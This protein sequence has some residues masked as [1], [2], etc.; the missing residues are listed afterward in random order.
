MI[1]FIDVRKRYGSAAAVDGVTLS[2]PEGELCVLLGPSGS[3]KTTLLRMTNRLVEPTSGT[4]RI[5][6]RDILA[7]DPVTLRRRIGYAIQSVGLFPH[8]T[9]AENIATTPELLGMK[10]IGGRIDEL[11]EMMKLDP[12][13][14]RDRYPAEL[15]GGEAQRVGV[16][17]A[18]A[19]D[20]PLL[21]MDEPFGAIDPINRAAIR[22]Q[23]L[24]LQGR[25]RKTIL[26]VSHDIQEAIQLA[27]RI[28]LLRDGRLEQFGTPAKLVA[29][30]ANRFVESFF[31]GDRRMLL[32][33]ALSAADA[34]EP[35]G[36]ASSAAI[37]AGTSLR[38]VLLALLSDGRT[39]LDVTDAGGT[40][41]GSITLDSI[42]RRVARA[43]AEEPQS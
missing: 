34:S 5:F 21:L 18:L 24:E 6:G 20:P 42:Q 43:L 11:L 16:A 26:F 28:A 3:G 27:D 17:R 4:I 23:F 9:V 41:I 12:A 15:S 22:E 10:G 1:E 35:G 7:D 29:S 36:A 19:A 2:V 39:A 30:P 25:L 8:R 32:L 14:Y 37:D 33:D 13:R 40:R 38:Q 31:G